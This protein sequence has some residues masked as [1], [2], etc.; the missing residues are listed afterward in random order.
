LTQRLFD[1]ARPAGERSYIHA[2]QLIGTASENYK[3][4]LALLTGRGATPVA[5]YNLIRPAFESAFHALWILDPADGQERCL[6]GLRVAVEDNRQRQ[7]WTAE[8]VKIPGLT[9]P[10][11]QAMLEPIAK[12]SKIYRDEAE[13][14]G[15]GWNRASQRVTVEQEIPKLSYVA[16]SEPIMRHM[17]V[18]GWKQLS[19]YQHGHVYAVVAG[20]DRSMELEIPG[21]YVVRVTVNDQHFVIA[22]QTAAL[23][24]LWPS[25]PTSAAQPAEANGGLSQNV[26]LGLIQSALSAA[27]PQRSEHTRR[28]AGEAGRRNCYVGFRRSYSSAEATSTRIGL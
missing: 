12:S 20:A 14:L 11:R 28:A 3:A 4:V 19:G 15:P 7:N 16:V 27:R 18:A 25:T 1:E 5:P 22:M 6:R 26:L 24:Q 10:Q 23:M 2:R 13:E 21:G 17:M 9:E 8:L